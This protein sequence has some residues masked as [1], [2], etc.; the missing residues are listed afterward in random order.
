M[1]RLPAVCIEG[2]CTLMTGHDRLVT[3]CSWPVAGATLPL[4]LLLLLHVS[5][6]SFA[7][8][9]K[10]GNCL[11]A[12]GRVFDAPAVIELLSSAVPKDFDH[13]VREAQ[14]RM[15]GRKRDKRA[16]RMKRMT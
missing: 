6:L 13:S 5:R 2:R 3:R 7:L 16:S 11:S 12:Y 15:P 10:S 14:R 8:G 1:P 4:P 9:P